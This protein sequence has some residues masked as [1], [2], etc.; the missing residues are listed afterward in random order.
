LLS[1]ENF[2]NVF[3]GS[4]K[5]SRN[6]CLNISVAPLARIEDI[7]LVNICYNLQA[8]TINIEWPHHG[9]A[10]E[11]LIFDGELKDDMVLYKGTMKDGQEIAV[12]LL[13]PVRY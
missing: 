2:G 1:N 7:S 13:C 5:C 10:G 8:Y 3:C 4:V 12:V 6:V 11:N 9:E